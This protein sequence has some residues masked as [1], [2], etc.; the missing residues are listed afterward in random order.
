VNPNYKTAPQQTAFHYYQGFAFQRLKL[1]GSKRW[2]TVSPVA[3]REFHSLQE[4]RQ[5]VRDNQ[6]T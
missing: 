5:W 6:T 2:R 4:A 1:S 3:G